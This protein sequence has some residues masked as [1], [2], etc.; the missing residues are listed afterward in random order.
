MKQIKRLCEITI[1]KKD[2]QYFEKE[3]RHMGQVAGRKGNWEKM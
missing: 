1:L 3:R 2:E